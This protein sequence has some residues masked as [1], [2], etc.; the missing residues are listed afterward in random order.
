MTGRKLA[1]GGQQVIFA[2]KDHPL[3]H[4]LWNYLTG[5]VQ[6][7]NIHKVEEDVGERGITFTWHDPVYDDGRLSPAI[8][9]NG[10]MHNVLGRNFRVLVRRP[11]NTGRLG[12]DFLGDFAA[13]PPLT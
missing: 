2:H 3:T 8:I 1:K 9:G 13:A 6:V 7:D 4:R 12:A 5:L 11:A 10:T